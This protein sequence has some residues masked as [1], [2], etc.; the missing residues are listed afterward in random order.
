MKSNLFVMVVLILASAVSAGADS[1][2]GYTA[3]PSKD[4]VASGVAPASALGTSTSTIGNIGKINSALPAGGNTI[5]SVTVITLPSTPAGTNTIGSVAVTILPALPAGTNLLG[6]VKAAPS[7]VGTTSVKSVT[8]T[9]SAITRSSGATALYL[10]NIGTETVWLNI[11]GVGATVSADI[12]LLT[13]TEKNF[14]MDGVATASVV[15]STPAT[16]VIFQP[17]RP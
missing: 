16:V 7:T 6:S 9:S 1:F 4:V 2:T 5:G 8:S 11:G 14:P 17:S 10:Y 12:P 3:T 13:N 15:S